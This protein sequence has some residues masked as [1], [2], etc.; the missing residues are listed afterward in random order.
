MCVQIKQDKYTVFDFWAQWCGPCKVVS[1]IFERLSEQF[2]AVEFYKVDVDAAED[3]AQ[4]MGLRAV[5][6][7]PPLSYPSCFL[8]WCRADGWTCSDADV[9]VVQERREDQ[10]RHRCEPERYPGAPYT[11]PVI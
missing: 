5:R 1:P 6:H 2:T 8:C 9:H 4:E 3:I 7:Q 10:G 11:S